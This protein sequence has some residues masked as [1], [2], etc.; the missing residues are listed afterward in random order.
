MVENLDAG[1][2]LARRRDE[3][4]ARIGA[5]QREL[6]LVMDAAADVAIDDEHDPEGATIAFERAQISFLLDE[7]RARLAELDAALDRYQRGSYGNCARCGESINAER[8]I[9]RPAETHCVAC[10]GRR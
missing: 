3:V 8:L 5:L 6:G 1:P 4:V 2:A 7:A 9:A 10:A